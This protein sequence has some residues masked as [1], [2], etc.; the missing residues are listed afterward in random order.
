MNLADDAVFGLLDGIGGYKQWEE[1]G[2]DFG[3]KLAVSA[4]NVA[5]GQAS[6]TALDGTYRAATGLMAKTGFGGVVARTMWSGVQTAT[7]SIASSAIN[8][9]N[10]QSTTR[11]VM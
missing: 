5:G 6:N 10:C 8:A 4:V 3:K 2:L 9:I 7:T 11:T 1:V